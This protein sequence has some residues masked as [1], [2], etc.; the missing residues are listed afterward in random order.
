MAYRIRCTEQKQTKNQ[1]NHPLARSIVVAAVV[2]LI[3]T[4]NTDCTISISLY[5]YSFSLSL[6]LSSK[7]QKQ[8]HLLLFFFLSLSVFCF[9]RFN[10]ACLS[11]VCPMM[12][13]CRVTLSCYKRPSSRLLPHA[14]LAVPLGL[15]PIG[16]SSQIRHHGSNLKSISDGSDSTNRFQMRRREN[17][18][19]PPSGSPPLP[20]IDASPLMIPNI[21][22]KRTSKA[23]HSIAGPDAT[24]RLF[25]AQHKICS[26]IWN[27]MERQAYSKSGSNS[28]RN[29]RT[30]P[31]SRSGHSSNSTTSSIAS[32]DTNTT[33]STKVSNDASFFSNHG[34]QENND[35]TS[36]KFRE[37]DFQNMKGGNCNLGFMLVGHGVP[38]QLLQDHVDCAWNMLNEIPSFSTKKEWYCWKFQ[39][40]R[41]RSGRVCISQ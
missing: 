5:S 19:R 32:S 23:S 27:Q 30:N 39:C 14:G 35:G 28:S 13:C 33:I 16:R 18:P 11:V 25:T 10:F 1:E 8:T 2:A 12:K 31:G 7:R 37:L 22:I 24:K 20:T 29:S 4:S 9:N 6:S 34:P 26:W 15:K 41:W 17:P 3:A 36:N 40:G 21:W 38:Y